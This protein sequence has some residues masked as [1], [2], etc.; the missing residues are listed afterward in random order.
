MP[1]GDRRIFRVTSCGGGSCRWSSSSRAPWRARSSARWDEIL[2]RLGEHLVRS[3]I[4]VRVGRLVD[5]HLADAF[6][7]VEP[8]H[9]GDEP[10]PSRFPTARRLAN[11]EHAVFVFGV[12]DHPGTSTKEECRHLRDQAVD[13]VLLER[14]DLA[15]D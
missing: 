13:E 7:E 1:R 15:P 14:N 9:L 12:L 5:E 2:A 6:A 11:P 3:R 10:A 8:E 4:E